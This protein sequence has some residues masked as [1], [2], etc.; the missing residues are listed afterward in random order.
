MIRIKIV[1]VAKLLRPHQYVKNLFVFL[2]VF[3]GMKFLDLH[4]L[5]KTTLAFFSFSLIASSVYIFNDI[6]DIEE[7]KK[8]PQK[9]FRP[10][11]SGQISQVEAYVLLSILLVLGGGVAVL[12][13]PVEF[14]WV[15]LLYI[16]LNAIYTLRL[17]HLA[18]LDI[19]IIAF[20]FVLRLFA[21]SV[22]GEVVLSRW[23]ILMTF[24]LALFLALAKR[25]DDFLMYMTDG[26]VLRKSIEGYN[27]S[28]IDTTMSIM[29]AVIIV[30]YVL[31]TVSPEV[32]KRFHADNL[33]FT[34]LFV[35]LG[36]LR[37]LQITL[38]QEKS[39][40]PT[41]ILLH[42]RPLQMAVIGWL[43]LFGLIIYF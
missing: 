35:I 42:D 8:H 20:G 11:A 18:I 30:A 6:H 19:A 24:L 15:L 25:R 37:F 12:W 32:T 33:Y 40:S 39:G 23:I 10:L 27:L 17:K 36:V 43:I 4:V 13:L 16:L 5:L 9:R 31:Y 14:I 34:T 21:G 26:K 28:F 1:S 7:D 41:K 3:F 22:A 2:P 38:V 29:A